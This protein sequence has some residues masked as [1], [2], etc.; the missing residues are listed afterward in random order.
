MDFDDNPDEAAFRAE[1]RAWIAANAPQHLQDGLRS[2]AAQTNSSVHT[3]D[4]EGQDP[5]A[6]SKSWQARKAEG[7]W[8]CLHWPA[9]YGGRG[10]SP[11]KRV[12]WQQE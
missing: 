4:I 9:K 3:P 1:A 5:V 8:A 11:M 2:A 6:I 10:A 7:G 12:I